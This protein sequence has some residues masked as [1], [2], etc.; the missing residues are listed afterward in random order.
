MVESTGASEQ[1]ILDVKLATEWS[2]MAKAQ[3]QTKTFVEQSM[4]KEIQ[5]ESGA[6]SLGMVAFFN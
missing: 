6:L 5:S 4:Q 3:E 1:G 2:K